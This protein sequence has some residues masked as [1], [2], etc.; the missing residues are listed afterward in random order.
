MIKGVVY[1]KQPHMMMKD[2]MDKGD[3]FLTQVNFWPTG[4]R[5]EM[6]PASQQIF[7]DSSVDNFVAAFGEAIRKKYP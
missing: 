1:D 5:E 3:M 4:L 6:R 2:L 7:V